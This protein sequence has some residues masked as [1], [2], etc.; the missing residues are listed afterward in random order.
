MFVRR[1][2]C[3]RSA[4]L[5]TPR[6]PAKRSAVW[7]T[8]GRGCAKRVAERPSRA[9]THG[10]IVVKGGG[11][12]GVFKRDTTN[13]KPFLPDW[14]QRKRGLCTG[15]ASDIDSLL[16]LSYKTITRLML[17]SRS[18][19]TPIDHLLCNSFQPF[20][21]GFYYFHRYPVIFFFP[22][23]FN[24]LTYVIQLKLLYGEPP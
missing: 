23:S 22:E 10:R 5:R 20:V 11:Q 17:A 24:L 7:R 1:Q 3:N 16:E 12:T 21:F 2:V 6:C 13:L 8:R 15:S 14:S 18:L 9:K 4:A 19:V